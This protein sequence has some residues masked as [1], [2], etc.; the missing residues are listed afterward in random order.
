MGPVLWREF[1]GPRVRAMYRAV[2]AKGRRI[3]IHSC[4][5]VDG[6]FAELAEYGL[7]CFNP[8]QP[9]VIDV[10]EAKRAHGARLSFYGGISTQRTLPFGTSDEV[11][12]EVRERIAIFS[13]GGGFVF[14]TIHNVQAKVPAENLRALFDTVK[15]A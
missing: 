10:F 12:R 3:F 13:P 5:K 1:I 4:G 14:N 9:E 6:L 8:F 2:R 7:D 15:G 11:R